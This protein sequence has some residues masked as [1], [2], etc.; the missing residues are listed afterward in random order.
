MNGWGEEGGGGGG[1]H[2]DAPQNSH[3]GTDEQKGAGLEPF[4][5]GESESH[6]RGSTGRGP[7]SKTRLD[8]SVTTCKEPAKEKRY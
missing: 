5:R 3:H 4:Q 1:R 7:M 6:R 8:Q 2:G